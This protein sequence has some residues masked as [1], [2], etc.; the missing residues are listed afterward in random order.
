MTA[1]WIA[2]NDDFADAGNADPVLRESSRLKAVL[3]SSGQTT[4]DP[5]ILG[6]RIG[7]VVLRHSFM[8]GT[9]F[10]VGPSVM[11]TEEGRKKIL[12]AS[13]LTFLTKDDPPVWAFYSVPVN[14]PREELTVSDAIH[15]PE[16]GVI[17]KEKMD[18][19]KIEC[20]LRHKDDGK[21][22]ID[23]MIAFLKKHLK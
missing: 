3:I 11:R 12:A 20:K 16:F 6:K 13:P 18:E 23:D 17:L 7:E 2:F 8:R 4:L 10:G 14:K 5:D 22:V 19:L 9:F 1:L 15:H 21:K